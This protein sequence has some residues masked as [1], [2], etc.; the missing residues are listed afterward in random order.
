MITITTAMIIGGE[1]KAD[2]RTVSPP[3]RNPIPTNVMI[4]IFAICQLVFGCPFGNSND[5]G[6]PEYPQAE[7]VMSFETSMFASSYAF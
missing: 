6:N 5:V 4:T 1:N 7:Q 3:N 2:T